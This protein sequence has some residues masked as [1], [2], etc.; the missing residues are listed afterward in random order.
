MTAEKPRL[1]NLRLLIIVSGLIIVACSLFAL[2]YAFWP[3][4]AVRDQV[5]LAPTL[6]APP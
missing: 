2:G 1:R 5:P 4:E 6:F 3:L